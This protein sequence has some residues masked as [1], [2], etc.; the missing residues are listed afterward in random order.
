MKGVVSMDWKR[1]DKLSILI[2]DDDQFTRELIK[3]I[4]KQVP[5]IKIYQAKDG[6]EA[7]T[8]IN[9]LSL[10]MILLDLYMPQMDGG[11]FI[12]TIRKN[13]QFQSLPIV[14]ITTDRLSKNELSKIG[15]D[16]YLTKPF[17]F[18]TFLES[19]YSF[20]EQE[21]HSNET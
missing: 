3:T 16:Y 5:N 7:L 6:I 13:S 19:I 14:L 4:L 17:D 20:F 2:I 8:F 10:D 21:V 1:F 9:E 12:E 11:E 15:A 18:H